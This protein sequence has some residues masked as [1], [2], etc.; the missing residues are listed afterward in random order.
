VVLTVD[1]LEGREAQREVAPRFVSKRR[2][3]IAVVPVLAVCGVFSLLAGN[4]L[5]ADTQFAQAHD[6]VL[7][8]TGRIAATEARLTAVRQDLRVLR[9]QVDASETFLSSDTTLLQAVRGA[10]VQ[11]QSDSAEKTQYIA[12]LK[13]CEG[14]IQQALNA[15]SVGDK[16]HAVSALTGVS[17]ACQSAAATSG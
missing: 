15:L 12:N 17:V 13:T 6:A 10:L 11:A 9:V 3:W 1:W 16:T 14:G 4:E 2:G 8:T 7:Q 5:Q